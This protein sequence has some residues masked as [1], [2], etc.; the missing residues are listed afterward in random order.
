MKICI[1]EVTDDCRRVSD[2]PPIASAG[3]S[4]TSSCRSPP[5][6]LVSR[7]QEGDA[8]NLMIFRNREP[9]FREDVGAYCLDFGG[10]VSMASVKNFQLIN[11]DDP[12]MGNILQFGR[13]AP[14]MFTMDFQWPLSP[15]QALAICLS[16]CDTKLACV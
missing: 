7:L 2:M 16:S 11:P 6:R 1:P 15:L 4:P 9:V 13:V 10:R 5:K 3:G 12:S 14:D 8:E